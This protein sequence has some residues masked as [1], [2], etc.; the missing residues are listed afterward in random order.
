MYQGTYLPELENEDWIL[1]VRNRIDRLYIKALGCFL[2]ILKEKIKYNE[3]I[4]ICEE[5][6]QY[7]FYEESIH[8]CFLDALMTTGQK[9]YAESHYEFYT[10]KF[11]HELGV[12]P[13]KEAREIYKRLSRQGE[14]KDEIV[15]LDT[16]DNVL[17]ENDTE[18]ALIC[19]SNYFEFLYKLEIRNSNRN[20]ESNICLGIITIENTGYKSL[21]EDEIKI[22]MDSLKNIMLNT[23]RKGDVLSQWN[24][25]QL[26]F[27]LYNVK[28][29]NLDGIMDRV[30]NKFEIEKKSSEVDLNIKCKNI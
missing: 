11:Y 30:K 12:A 29:A 18:G 16:I 10:T 28:E 15:D 7:N 1:P 13:S 3:I 8:L 6:M 25:K 14:K 23:L 21:K 9:R 24:D 19:D 5:A 26:V 2:G 20:E 27:L 4:S 17:Q 22:A